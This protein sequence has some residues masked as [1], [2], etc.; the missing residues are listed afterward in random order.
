MQSGEIWDPYK[1]FQSRQKFAQFLAEDL[2]YRKDH[3]MRPIEN[4]EESYCFG[5][6]PNLDDLSNY[7]YQ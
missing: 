4:L 6:K 7:N 2:V 5:K 3:H 1:H